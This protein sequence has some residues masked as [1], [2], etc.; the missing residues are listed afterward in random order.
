M[1][2]VQRYEYD[3]PIY[4]FDRIHTAKWSAE[5]VAKSPEE[6]KRNIISQAKKKLRLK[7]TARVMILSTKIKE[8]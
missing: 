4:V 7:Q 3:G 5:T 8:I 1:A 2:I 6:A